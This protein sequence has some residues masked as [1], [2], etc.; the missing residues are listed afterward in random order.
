MNS[1]VAGQSVVLSTTIR[2]VAG[3]LVN[4]DEVTC[5]VK[6]PDGTVATVI[7]SNP[8][9][10]LYEGN[11]TTALAGMHYYR[12]ESSS[13]DGAVEGSFRVNGSLV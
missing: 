4:P 1:Y 9:T 12:F 13:P 6:R 7:L 10:G 2:D 11:F 3:A 5:E 8:S